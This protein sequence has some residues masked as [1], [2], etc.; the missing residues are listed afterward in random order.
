MAS[1]TWTRFCARGSVSDFR[2]SNR[3]RLGSFGNLTA[4][5]ELG[6]F[7]NKSI[8]DAEKSFITASTKGNIIN[9]SRQAVI[10]DDLGAFVGLSAMLGHAAG[11]TVESDVYALLG[12]NSGQGPT[13][14][15]TGHL[16]N[17]TAVTSPGGHANRANYAAPTV[18]LIDAGRQAD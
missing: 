18:L 7:T 4:V 1:F 13:M 12:L 15:D 3:Y 17:S 16:F 6:E 10:N 5:N 9:L 2:P 14:S 8:P 11:R